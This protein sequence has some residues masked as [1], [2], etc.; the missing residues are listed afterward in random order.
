MLD[1]DPPLAAR[2]YG[3]LV[4]YLGAAI[5][6]FGAPAS[7][8]DHKHA[9]VRAEDLGSVSVAGNQHRASKCVH[10]RG[11]APSRYA[12]EGLGTVR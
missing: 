5:L 2:N 4:S 12:A 8:N 1:S 3:E 6:A 7:S 9:G 11:A 10:A